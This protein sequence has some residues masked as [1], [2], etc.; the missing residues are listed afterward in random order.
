M[1]DF[2][3][4]PSSWHLLMDFLHLFPVAGGNRLLVCGG[5]AAAVWASV[6]ERRRGAGAA[7]GA[8]AADAGQG[9]GAARLHAV[10]RRRPALLLAAVRSGLVRLPALLPLQ[11]PQPRGP[12]RRAG[13]GRRH[14]AF[15]FICW[16]ADCRFTWAGILRRVLNVLLALLA[17]R[18]R[19]DEPFYGKRHKESSCSFESSNKFLLSKLL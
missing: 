5:A 9:G 12:Q 14:P 10:R 17:G 1:S 16:P 11:P 3:D 7:G 15:F 4:N 2:T 13:A 6:S 19:L 18:E 8:E